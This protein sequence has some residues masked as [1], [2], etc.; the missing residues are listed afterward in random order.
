MLDCWLS[1]LRDSECLDSC[2]VADF[3]CFDYGC[4]GLLW[5]NVQIVYFHVSVCFLY[6]LSC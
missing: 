1:E 2:R 5:L 6:L 4:L 3:D